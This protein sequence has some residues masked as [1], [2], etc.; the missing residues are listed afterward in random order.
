MAIVAI[1]GH[2]NVEIDEIKVDDRRRFFPFGHSISMCYAFQSKWPMTCHSIGV[3]I[4]NQTMLRIDLL[5]TTTL[6][7]SG[8]MTEGCREEV[9]IFWGSRPAP[10]NLCVDLAE[11]TYID[12][13]GKETLRWLGQLGA[14][15][16]A[17]NPYALHVLERLHLDIA[18]PRILPGDSHHTLKGAQHD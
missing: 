17:D 12:H 5:G 18:E 9:E 7:M 15:F 4:G 1:F 16:A 10:S 14:K 6:R 2:A 11:V 3:S 8:R 13:A